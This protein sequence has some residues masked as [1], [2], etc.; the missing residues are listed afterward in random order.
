MKDE[1]L[2]VNSTFFN[3]FKRKIQVV[4][5]I[6]LVVVG[7]STTAFSIERAKKFDKQSEKNLKKPESTIVFTQRDPKIDMLIAC[8]RANPQNMERVARVD[9][10]QKTR[11]TYALR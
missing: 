1:G 8:A 6:V 3:S 2:I 7:V 4:T 9:L 10:K 5:S 11:D